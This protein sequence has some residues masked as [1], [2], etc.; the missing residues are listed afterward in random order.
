[1]L[2]AASVI[3][4]SGLLPVGFRCDGVRVL[5]QGHSKE[6]EWCAMGEDW[7]GKLE[8]VAGIFERYARVPNLAEE[9]AR[10]AKKTADWTR[11]RIERINVAL[12]HEQEAGGEPPATE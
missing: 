1:M 4:A 6:G 10:E 11:R 12:Q 9:E 7:S 2:A 8:E 3:A 5:T